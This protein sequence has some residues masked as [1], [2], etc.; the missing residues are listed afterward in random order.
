MC[1][2]QSDASSPGTARPRHFMSAAMAVR[3]TILRAAILGEVQF[4][5]WKKKNRRKSFFFFVRFPTITT[6]DR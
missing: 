4:R 3:E 1:M 6:M 5:F 2:A